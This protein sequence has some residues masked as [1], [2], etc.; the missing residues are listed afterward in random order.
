[1][2]ANYWI[3]TQREHWTYTR[4]QLNEARRRLEEDEAKLVQQFQLPDRRHISIF[5]YN[6]QS[7]PF[8]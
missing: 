8:S 5:F 4:P 6:R 1:M 7:L 2:A 3:S